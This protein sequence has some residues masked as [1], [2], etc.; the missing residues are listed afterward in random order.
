MG[1]PDFAVPP[2]CALAKYN[3]SIKLVITQ[4]DRPKGRGKKTVAPPVKS[5][6][7]ELGLDILQP[8]SMDKKEVKEKLIRLKPDFFVVVAFGHKLSREILSIP[9]VLPINIHAS[10][11]PKYRGSSPIQA[12]ILNM[13]EKTGVTTMVMDENLDTGDILLSAET[14]IKCDATA[15][16]LHDILA[17]MGADLIIKTLDAIKDG[18][19]VPVP[20]NDNLAS[21]APMLKKSDGRI[22]WKNNPEK[23]NAFIRAMTPWPGAFTFLN[24]KRIKIFRVACTDFSQH[25]ELPNNI[26]FDEYICPGTVV[27][28]DDRGI[29]VAAGK[30][31]FVT[32]VELQTEG[33]KR[34]NACEFLKGKKLETGIRFDVS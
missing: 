5:A 32:I 23:I 3:C 20:Q 18:E 13:D 21:F 31:G 27:S 29:C 30:S 14:P 9:S 6:A 22:N 24:G 7:M 17:Q 34:L 2:L 8:E 12:A 11:L 19:I 4:P 33:G 15:S 25:P 16:D 26:D 28:C 1:T 10:L